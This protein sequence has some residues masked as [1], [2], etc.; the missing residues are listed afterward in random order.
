MGNVV[1]SFKWKAYRKHKT[2]A[3]DFYDLA[4]QF[5]RNGEF[6]RAK[7]YFNKSANERVC[8]DRLWVNMKKEL[9]PEHVAFLLRTLKERDQC[10][11]T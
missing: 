1:N 11:C 4:I 9:N 10:K 5:Q 7:E 6:C 3:H 2:N 8:A